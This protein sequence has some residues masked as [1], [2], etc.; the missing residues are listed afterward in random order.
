[1][2]FTHPLFGSVLYADAP[3]SERRAVHHR[4]AELVLDE[5]E[6]ARHLAFAATRP[7]EE[8]ALR[9]ERAA[10]RARARGA[11]T[12]AAE[13][14]ERA[15]EL[16]PETN[17]TERLR[18][19]LDAAEFHLAGRTPGASRILDAVLPKTSGDLRARAL[20]L[21]AVRR[22]LV[23]YGA[24]SPLL[25][26]A[27][28]HVKDP[29]LELQIRLEL[30]NLILRGATPRSARHADRA[31]EL[32][33][34][35]GDDGLLAVAIASR[36]A[37]H[38]DPLAE[39]ERAADLERRSG[40]NVH[41]RLQLAL[42]QLSRGSDAGRLS[43][44]AL[45]EQSLA[46]G[47]RAHNWVIGTL[48]HAETRAGNFQRG[49]QL[50]SEFRGYTVAEQNRLGESAALTSRA[51]AEA[52]LGELDEARHDAETAIRLA[53]E[54][55]YEGRSIQG[56]A[57][58][59]FIA[60]SAGETERSVRPFEEAAARAL[61]VDPG[62][63]PPFAISRLA[64][65]IALADAVE[66]FCEMGRVDETR[67][68]IAWLER[69]HRNPW[70]QGLAGHCRGLVA[71]ARRD[72]DPA[73]AELADAARRL[74]PLSLPLDHGRALLALGSAQRRAGEKA[75]AR[76][77]LLGALETFE[78][79]GAPLWGAK[80]ENELARIGG[81]PRAEHGLTPSE[82][83]VAQLVAAGRTNKEVAAALFISAKT[84]EGHLANVYEK[85]GVRSRAELARKMASEG[86]AGP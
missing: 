71:A 85:L 7:D 6:A 2:R 10:A 86:S 64:I 43:L 58:L 23:E 40:A 25:E 15:S 12:A 74:E 73:V 45:L 19:A 56:R 70:H 55:G 77:A 1:V 35:G 57:L 62:R 42:L 50:A 27:L 41:A 53:D 81:R 17:S 9:L 38:E 66:A 36:A 39:L 31:V 60:L 80:A 49:K 44:N 8:V 82:V 65:P 51:Y 24:P 21:M 11:T 83:R 69:E 63:L 4:L 18:R 32:A 33:E 52:C 59:G 3:A 37:L 72:H 14:I 13:L 22:G 75:E 76:P 5:E 54:G 29:A 79:I 61:A 26:E 16:T 48:A 46:A 78:R 47:I 28:E 67:P 84:V 34:Q 20:L 30:V 68:L